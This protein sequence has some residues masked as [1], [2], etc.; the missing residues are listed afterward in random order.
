M[1]LERKIEQFK[2]IFDI[3][4][5]LVETSVIPE[6]LKHVIES[7]ESLTDFSHT[8]GGIT[9]IIINHRN[10]IYDIENKVLPKLIGFQRV[11]KKY[12]MM[13]TAV[14]KYSP[15]KRVRVK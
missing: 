15:R 2:Q 6:F 11:C 13:K 9:T 3:P 14:D 1:S 5:P 8:F 10:H 7:N 12:L 4:K